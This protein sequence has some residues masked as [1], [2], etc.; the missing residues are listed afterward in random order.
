MNIAFNASIYHHNIMIHYYYLIT[1]LEELNDIF[2]QVQE[3]SANA[4]TMPQ[5]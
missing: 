1:S 2:H 5:N 4:I 3:Y